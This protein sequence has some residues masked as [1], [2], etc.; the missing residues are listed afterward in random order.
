MSGAFIRATALVRG[1]DIRMAASELRARAGLDPTEWAG[2]P[3]F[4]GSSSQNIGA[5][6]D[7]AAAPLAPPLEFAQQLARSF[8]VCGRVLST[9]SGCTSGLTALQLALD[10]LHAGAY[11]H[12]LVLGVEFPNRLTLAGFTALGLVPGM[13]LGHALGALVV[14]REGRW[15]IAS[16]AWALDVAVLSGAAPDQETILRAM[17]GALSAARW[18]PAD[19]DLVKLQATGIA[20]SDEAETRALAALFSP[21]PRSLS[22]KGELGH[23]LGASGPAEL[24]LLLEK[25]EPRNELRV[26]F[27]LSGFGGQVASLALE[28]SA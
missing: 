20:E 9:T 15:R 18:K 22:L 17:H 5:V 2:L 8:G 6:E 24:A 3:C 13:T 4:V 23:T 7:D 28:R 21:M 14:S 26:L 27:N 1:T 10:L 16:L 25:L 12:A 11:S 19:V